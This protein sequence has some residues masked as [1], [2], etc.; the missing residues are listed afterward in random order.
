MDFGDLFQFVIFLLLA[1]AWL[2]AGTRKRQQRPTRPSPQRRPRAPRQPM[3][4]EELTGAP[5]PTPP[6]ERHDWLDLLREQLETAAGGGLPPPEPETA[7]DAVP[8]APEAQ[9]L[10]TLEPAGEASHRRFHERYV[11]QAPAPA[12]RPRADVFPALTPR[13]ARQAIVWREILGPPK[14]LE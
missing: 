13:T 3:P 7:L 1:L 4:P 12:P 11:E 14:G 9:S 8:L 6:L 10:E 5:L 2:F